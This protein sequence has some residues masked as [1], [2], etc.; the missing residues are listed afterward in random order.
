MGIFFKTSNLN[1]GDKMKATFFKK[2]FNM[3]VWFL[4]LGFSLLPVPRNTWAQTGE[5][6]I[7][8]ALSEGT[9]PLGETLSE[10][11]LLKGPIKPTAQQS[12]S[13]DGVATTQAQGQAAIPAEGTS[14]TQPQELLAPQEGL[15]AGQEDQ[16][17]QPLGEGQASL[18]QQATGEE[19]LPRGT[20]PAGSEILAQE[21]QPVGEEQAPMVDQQA[22]S[23]EI[24]QGEDQAL[25]TQEVQ[26]SSEQATAEPAL[27]PNKEVISM[28]KGELDHL[29]EVI[30]KVDDPA[31]KAEMLRVAAQDVQ[32]VVTD[33]AQADN[34]NNKPAVD[35]AM[36]EGKTD[37]LQQL[38]TNAPA[39][40]QGGVSQQT[41]SALKE[42][43]GS[44]EI[45]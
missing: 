40:L 39:L 14:I 7:Q 45:G 25:S 29:Q 16:A 41:I 12:A 28:S 20:Q 23:Q 10:E 15:G 26:P 3:F 9:P 13:P 34:E 35:I 21:G 27:D 36:A 17:L 22:A 6:D 38:D 24:P 44:G 32:F 5:A 43:I 37:A 2:G 33:T 11:D 18:D 19:N 8:P 4:V 31:L 1:K 42:A 30:A